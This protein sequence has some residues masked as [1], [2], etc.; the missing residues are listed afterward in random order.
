MV[1][2][3]KCDCLNITI[4]LINKPIIWLEENNIDIL[5]QFIKKKL[6]WNQ[7]S[8]RTQLSIAGIHA[9]LIFSHNLYL[10]IETKMVIKRNRKRRVSRLENW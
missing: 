4:H 10:L 9:V 7:F 2:L 6:N 3:F 1:Y 8:Q 5:F